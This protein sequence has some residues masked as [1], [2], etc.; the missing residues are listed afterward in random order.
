MA[1]KYLEEMKEKYRVGRV[2]SGWEE[3]RRRFFEERGM[4]A[5]EMEGKKGGKTEWFQELV[6]RDREKQRKEERER[7]KDSRYDR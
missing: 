4:K 2:N 5:E 7:I 1:R 3:E 6:D